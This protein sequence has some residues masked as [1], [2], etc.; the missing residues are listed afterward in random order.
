[1]KPIK[2]EFL[3]I[4]LSSIQKELIRSAAKSA[5][6]DMSSWIMSKV[7]NNQSDEFLNI[8]RKLISNQKQSYIYAEIHDYLM[9]CDSK[10]FSKSVEAGPTGMLDK[11]QLNYVAAMVEHRAKQLQAIIPQW[12]EEIP[13]LE[14]PFFGSSLKSLKLYL[15]LNS[16]LA[17]RRRKIFIDSTVG[18]RV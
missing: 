16:P 4:R 18:S 12:C 1:M 11:F 5:N 13:I 14:T 9:K 2:D 17:F 10:D 7:I 8:V 15:L 6:T 3:Q